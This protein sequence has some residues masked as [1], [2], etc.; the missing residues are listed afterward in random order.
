[1]NFFFDDMPKKWFWTLGLS[2]SAQ[3]GPFDTYEEA[4]SD[5]SEY[6]DNMNLAGLIIP[7]LDVATT[8]RHDANRA[9]PPGASREPEHS[10]Q[11]HGSSI[12]GRLPPVVR[13]SFLQLV[14]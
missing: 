9:T 10:P 3:N 14:G 11:P 4:Q 12:P 6:V 1:M 2:D 8:H 13:G 5:F 7:G